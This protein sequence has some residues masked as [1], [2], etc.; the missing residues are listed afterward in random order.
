MPLR[1]LTCL[2]KA[3]THL[4]FGNQ[5]D[6]WQHHTEIQIFTQNVRFYYSKQISKRQ[7]FFKNWQTQPFF[8]HFLKKNVTRAGG[9]RL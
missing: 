9:V 8:V 4:S 7:F 3:T 1:S 6:H 5:A 2:S